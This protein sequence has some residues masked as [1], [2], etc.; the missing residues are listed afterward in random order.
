MF[1]ITFS[2]LSRLTTQIRC[3]GSQPSLRSLESSFERRVERR[4]R[5][6]LKP[7]NYV[8][9]EMRCSLVVQLGG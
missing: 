2:K 4:V 8:G 1:C 7:V 5:W 3:C 6:K 9:A